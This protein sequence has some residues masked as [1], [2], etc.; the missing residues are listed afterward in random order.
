MSAG[1]AVGDLAL[2]VDDRTS[3]GSPFVDV[4]AGKSYVVVGFDPTSARH[5]LFGRDGGGL[6]LDGIEART[7]A[8][9]FIKILPD[10]HEACEQEFVTL[11][12][13]R[14]VSA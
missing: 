14:K 1:W 3:R 13:R 4:E 5:D 9:R 7:A 11:L 8:A 10:K 6:V 2:C 12:N